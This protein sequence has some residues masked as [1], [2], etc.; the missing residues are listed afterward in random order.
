MECVCFQKLLIISAR[1]L[2][3][4]DRVSSKLQLKKKENQSRSMMNDLLVRSPS[5]SN[6]FA[7]LIAAD[8]SIS[9]HA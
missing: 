7:Y 1:H 2:D 3:Q 8:V 6:I 5:G 9:L 4:P